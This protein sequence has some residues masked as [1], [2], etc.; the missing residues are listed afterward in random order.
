M[1][2]KGNDNIHYVKL[3]GNRRGHGPN[4][5]GVSTYLTHSM[6]ARSFLRMPM[7]MFHV[8]QGG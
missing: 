6:G 4:Q 8:E 7:R 3:H 1:A 2:V 5:R